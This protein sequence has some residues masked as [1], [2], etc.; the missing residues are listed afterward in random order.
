MMKALS[1]KLQ[2]GAFASRGIP[3]PGVGLPQVHRN[4]NGRGVAPSLLISDGTFGVRAALPNNNA[5]QQAG[6]HLRSKQRHSVVVAVSAPE[7]Q[8]TKFAV[9]ETFSL[10]K[11]NE[12]IRVTVEQKADGALTVHL[13]TSLQAGRLLLHWGVEGGK[14]YQGGW[15]LPSTCRPP[16]TKQYKDR[17]LQSPFQVDDHGSH[18]FI[19]LSAEEASDVLNFV[20]KDDATNTWYDNSG[21]NFRLPLHGEASSKTSTGTQVIPKALADKWAWMRW[22]HQGRP[23]QSMPDA[24]KDYERGVEEMRALMGV[25]R[26]MDELWRVA[27]G[28]WPYPKYLDEVEHPAFGDKYDAFKVRE[29]Q[30]AAGGVSLGPVP[31]ELLSVQAYI[32]WEKAG[33]PQG[34]DFADE[35]LRII[36][37][38]VR[39]GATYEQ[40]AKEMNLEPTWKKGESQPQQQAPQEAKQAPPAAPEVGKPL[41]APKRNPLDLV[42]P[43]GQAPVLSERKSQ[44]EEMPL[45]FLEARWAI[46]PSTKW[47]R[48]YGLGN[49]SEMLVVV[50]QTQETDPIRVDFITDRADKLILHW[51]VS[52][53]GSRSWKMPPEEM[54]DQDSKQATE[55]AAESPFLECDDEEECDLEY[56]GA[57]VP[58]QRRTITLP[59]DSWVGA[60]SC[61]LRS[62]DATMWYKDGGGD[63]LIPVPCKHVKEGTQLDAMPQLTDDLSREI[64]DSENSS[65]WTLMHRFNKATD[66]INNVANGQYD[67]DPADGFA[68]IYA[69]LR[70]SA[71]RKLTWQR[72]YN[73]QPR[74]LSGSQERLTGTIASVH[75]RTAGGVH[76]CAV[77]FYSFAA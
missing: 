71:T 37:D 23:Q 13:T 49:K 16:G 38:R 63:F 20:L 15:R 62:A 25:G 56:M 7:Q 1:G 51:G 11:G 12:T 17:A 34:A 61:V 21:S 76:V 54:R 46:D 10:P 43:Q 72:N 26:S 74:Q 14:D 33:Q 31:T 64:V 24:N 48:K 65:A 9:D 4:C 40:L 36:E 75:A 35:A 66:L 8:D 60:I 55:T 19:M 57:K 32:C 69:W 3:L 6:M 53:P 52:K 73:T 50:R 22:D 77:C 68:R 2:G 5:R 39:G 70:Y 47:R 18:L 27:E 67:L 29:E 28:K 59:A 45:D 44:R 41:G 58:L 30:G 42:K